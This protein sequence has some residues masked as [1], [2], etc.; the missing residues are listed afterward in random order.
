MALENVERASNGDTAPR[1]LLKTACSG[2][3]RT[4][5]YERALSLLGKGQHPRRFVCTRHPSPISDQN[6]TSGI[7]TTATC[8]SICASCPV[9]DPSSCLLHTHAPRHVSK[10]TTKT[11]PNNQTIK[12]PN[13]RTTTRPNEQT[14]KPHNQSTTMSAKIITEMRGADFFELIKSVKFVIR[15]GFKICS[16]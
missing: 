13:E 8:F 11:Q 1:L 5:E 7:R 14:N 15:C 3:P 9:L 12:R 10:K 16:N 2:A 6:G 4:K